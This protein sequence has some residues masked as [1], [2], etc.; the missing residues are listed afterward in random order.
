[1]VI[2][3]SY[4]AK[5]IQPT[6]LSYKT[7][8]ILWCKLKS[9]SKWI[10]TRFSWWTF[11]L[12]LHDC[13]CVFFNKALNESHGEFFMPA[14]VNLQL[15]IIV[16][17]SYHLTVITDLDVPFNTWLSWCTFNWLSWWTFIQLS[18][19]IFIHLSWCIFIHLSWCTFIRLSWCTFNWLSLLTFNW[20]SW[21]TFTWLLWCSFTWLTW[22]IFN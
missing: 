4:W 16:K 11:M 12:S 9:L 6:Q 22:W 15:S 21:C 10:L 19:C 7:F 17:V 1:M 2:L 20:L 18:W 5:P 3:A 14:K 8:C 13:Q